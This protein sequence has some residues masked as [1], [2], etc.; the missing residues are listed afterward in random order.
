M[1]HKPYAEMSRIADVRTD[2]LK[3]SMTRRQRLER[4][5]EVLEQEPAR[6]LRSLEEIEWKPRTERRAVRADGSPLTVAFEDPVL[7]A[8]G[9]A[10]DRLGD[11]FDFFELSVHDAH[12]ALCSCV[13]GR[14]MQAG[15]AA[16]RVRRLIGPEW[17]AINNLSILGGG[18]IAL[19][20][21][22]GLAG[23]VL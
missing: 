20:L 6:E 3:P 4:W 16:G 11:A 22:S 13:Y 17:Q 7:R 1:E 21:L 15:A 5:A 2:P 19:M 10:S 14:T 18:V 8:E 23:L 12:F 9:L